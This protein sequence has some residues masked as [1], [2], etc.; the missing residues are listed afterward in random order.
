MSQRARPRTRTKPREGLRLGPHGTGEQD[1][2]LVEAS[3]VDGP[4]AE[5][6]A[7]C[8]ADTPEALQQVLL[9]PGRRVQTNCHD[10]VA[11]FR[12][13][14]GEDTT[15]LPWLWVRR[16]P[17]GDAHNSPVVMF[18]CADITQWRNTRSAE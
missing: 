4:L 10:A 5:L 14:Y 3:G 17:M 8:G 6:A 11:A 2:P 16:S 15:G 9:I 13:A 7:L 12:H 1:G 18:A